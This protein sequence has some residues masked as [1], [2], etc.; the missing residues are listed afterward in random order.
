LRRAEQLAAAG[1]LAASISHEINNPLEAVTNLLYLAKL[2]PELTPET[3]SRLEVADKE[4]QRLSHIAR[5]SLRFYR[6]TSSPSATSVKELF[7]A[8]LMVFQSRITQNSITVRTNFVEAP[9][10]YCYPGELQQVFTNLIANSLDALP[11]AGTL[12]IFVRPS[13]GGR[14]WEQEGIRVVIADNGTGMDAGTLTRAFEPFF[15]T[16]NE[17]GTGLGL[18]V[19]KGIVDKHHGSIG[20]ASAPG[21]GTVMSLFFPYDGVRSKQAA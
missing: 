10:L 21:R 5:T 14:D 15:T 4:L 7:Q 17:T 6:Q 9:D 20:V 16:K 13:H 1:K 18:W 3:Q 11:A 2:A 12:A 19:S 8:V